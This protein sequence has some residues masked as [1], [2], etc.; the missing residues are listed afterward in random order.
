MIHLDGDNRMT[1]SEALDLLRSRS[2]QAA[3]QDEIE[4]LIVGGEAE[5]GA[6]LRESALA[7]RLG[8]SRGPVREA[9][10]ALEEKGLVTVVKHCGAFVR[11]IGPEEADEIYDVRCVLEAAIGERVVRAIDAPGLAALRGLVDAMALAAETRDADQYASLN[12]AFHDALARSSGNARLHE[13][14]ARLVAELAL[15]RRHVH[16]HRL[17]TLER[18]L[19]EHRAIVEAIVASRA[20]EASRLL[21][22]HATRSRARLADAIA[23]DAPSMTFAGDA[24]TDLPRR[25]R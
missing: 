8:V 2:L 21:V 23:S 1:S 17:D 4:R 25:H 18:S 7:R 5:P 6:A 3:V 12:L 10:R 9:L 24:G 11:R 22:E 13:T 14:Y 16:A 15:L 20:D 19:A